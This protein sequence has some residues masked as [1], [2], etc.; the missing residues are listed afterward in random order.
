MTRKVDEVEKAGEAGAAMT[1]VYVLMVSGAPVAVY[2]F[3]ADARAAANESADDLAHY[4]A[5]PTHF[6]IHVDP[7]ITHAD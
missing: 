3:E 2:L 5:C 4:I 7:A 1:P 6:R